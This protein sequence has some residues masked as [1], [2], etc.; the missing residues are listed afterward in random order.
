MNE[1]SV[2]IE[3]LTSGGVWVP[4]VLRNADFDT[5]ENFCD[6]M[7]HYVA[8][9]RKPDPERAQFIVQHQ[10]LFAA[11]GI[12]LAANGAF[13]VRDFIAFRVEESQW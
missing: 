13:V 7:A 12:L 8:A 10:K 4:A 1:K 2:T 3:M 11:S 9:V 5:A 6:V